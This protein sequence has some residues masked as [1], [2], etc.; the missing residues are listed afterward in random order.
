MNQKA[1]SPHIPVLLS[2]VLKF[3]EDQHLKVFYE[4]TVGAGGHA[5]A[6]LTSHPEIEKYIAC[7]RDP[8][9]LEMAKK[10]LEPWAEKIDFVH[11]SFENLDWHLAERE[12]QNV[13]GFFLIWGCL[14]CN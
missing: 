14:L 7:D 1:S 2:E 11:G 8:E 9:A 13:D 4:G 10:R 6:L 12:I 5:E 3:F